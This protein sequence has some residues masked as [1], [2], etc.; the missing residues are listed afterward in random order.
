MRG[1][2]GV[3]VISILRPKLSPAT[4]LKYDA[5]ITTKKIT[6]ADSKS[7]NS[8]KDFLALPKKSRAA[9][10]ISPSLPKPREAFLDRHGYLTCTWYATHV[11]GAQRKSPPLQKLPATLCFD[12]ARLADAPHEQIRR[13]TKNYG[14]LG[15]EERAEE[16]VDAWSKWARLARA[17]LRFAG[18]RATG[19]SGEEEDWKTICEYAFSLAL[20]RHRMH[21]HQQMAI[22]A[23]AVNKWFAKATG[24]R[25]LEVV[26]GE[27]QVRPGASNLFGILISQIAR[28]MARS[29]QTV[30]CAG[31]K[32][33]FLPTR[34]LVR[35]S[36]QY[37]TRCRK[38][39]VPQRD[40]SRDWRR[41][42]R[43]KSSTLS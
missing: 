36:R 16:H 34:P 6:R 3:C 32:V 20:D 11:R 41:R 7:S 35:G 28:V 27:L 9:R 19:G 12:F 1:G 43:A 10:V 21:A 24:H 33:P 31:C 13:F 23:A 30:V 29:D 42:L 5:D 38:A 25:I 39:K 4:D 15:L 22:A 26:D 40:A 37:C 18:E 2:G 17:L 14:L 8:L